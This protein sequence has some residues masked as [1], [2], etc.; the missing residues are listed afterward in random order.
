MKHL[1][2]FLFALPLLAAAQVYPLDEG[3][4]GIP[5]YQLP[6]G[7]SGDMRVMPD[8]GL[9]DD[10]GAAADISGTDE[11]DSLITPWVG[12]LD[13]FTQVLFYYRMVEDFIYPSTEKHLGPLDNLIVSVSTDSINYTPICIIDSSNHLPTLNFRK[14]D[15]TLNNYAGQVVK[16]K[17]RA[18]TGGGSSY[19]TDIDSIKIRQDFTPN[20]GISPTYAE[21]DFQLSPNPANAQHT[22]TVKTGYNGNS[23]VQ[24]FD[25]NGRQ[26]ADFSFEKE[27]QLPLAGLPAGLYYVR[28][29]QQQLYSIKKLVLTP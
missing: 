6:A 22:A 29:Q 20:T 9:N 21:L 12:P 16:F 18:Q 15:F 26:L 23:L 11:V 17:F 19:F 5:T 1:L 27:L 24:L 14:I 3:F 25:G 2:F 8:H 28:L 10:K 13:T 4:H 7:W